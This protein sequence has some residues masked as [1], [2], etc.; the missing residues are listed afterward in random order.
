VS[1]AATEDRLTS[2]GLKEALT[3]GGRAVC[4]VRS[5]VTGK[6]V[7]VRLSAKKR[8]ADGWVSR[9]TVAGRVGIGD[10]TAIFAEDTD[11]EYPE[12]RIGS[13]YFKSGEWRAEEDADP[14]RVWA[15]EKLL[16]WAL[17]G[18]DLDEYA[19]IFLAAECVYCGRPLTDP[20]SVERGIGPECFGRST[21]SKAVPRS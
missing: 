4:T 20:E 13:F 2:A 9:A 15:A 5:R 18:F 12:N 17:S 16:Y 19:E 7:T 14:A 10:A 3:E 8:A 21:K 1:A 11:L 6:H